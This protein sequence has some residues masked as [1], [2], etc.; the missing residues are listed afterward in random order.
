M[1]VKGRNVRS[2]EPPKTAGKKAPR[3]S[4]KTVD[5]ILGAAKA[6]FLDDGFDGVNLD[7][8]AERAGVSRQTVY[9]RFGS[10]EAVFRAMIERHWEIFGG[11]AFL[12][13]LS[14][15]KGGPEDV[16]R[17]FAK[18]ILR[19]VVESDQVSFTRLVIAESRRLPWI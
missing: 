15:D 2:M 9:N 11:D 4:G 14:A 10:K 3:E 19:F 5:A 13:G 8:I 1:V 12:S 16:L 18:T 17:Y 7:R 6:L